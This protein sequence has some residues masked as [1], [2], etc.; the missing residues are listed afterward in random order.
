MFELEVDED[1]ED[2]EDTGE[3]ANVNNAKTTNDIKSSI[4]NETNR[5]EKVTNL[6]LNNSIQQQQQQKFSEITTAT[7]INLIKTTTSSIISS[8]APTSSIA[9]GLNLTSTVTPITTTTTDL[10]ERYQ[11]LQDR[12]RA[13]RK[14][15]FEDEDDDTIEFNITNNTDIAASNTV[16]S[17]T[18]AIRPN[19]TNNSSIS[20]IILISNQT[21]NES[22][23]RGSNSMDI[24]NTYDS[25][26]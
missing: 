7:P 5:E 12:L 2:E 6:T 15:E 8:I 16:D 25:S 23:L 18:A 17:I 9:P 21:G 1:D 26:S 20:Q 24:S 22:D 19:D 11:Q 13:K 10:N 14:K 3:E 4:L